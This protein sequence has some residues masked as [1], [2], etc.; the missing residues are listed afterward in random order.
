MNKKEY[1]PPYSRV[2]DY[3]SGR[4]F[5]DYYRNRLRESFSY[6][7]GPC[8]N[9]YCSICFPKPEYHNDNTIQGEV[10]EEWPEIEA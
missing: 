6:Y 8:N 4:I 7:A 5:G 3:A 2:W 9:E 10:V 1:E